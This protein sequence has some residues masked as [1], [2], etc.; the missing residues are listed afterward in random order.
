MLSLWLSVGSPCSGAY[1]MPKILKCLRCGTEFQPRTSGGEPQ[2][3][4]S[5]RCR[6]NVLAAAQMRRKRQDP[7]FAAKDRVRVHAWKKEHPETRRMYKRARRQKLSLQKGNFTTADWHRLLD[8]FGHKCAYCDSPEPLERD[9]IVPV[10]AGGKH[11]V[12]NV[13]PV[14]RKCNPSKGSKDLRT[15]LADEDRYQFVCD[16]IVLGAMP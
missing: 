2:V 10:T 11:D 7:A 16:T 6:R 5:G 13:A 9:H 8:I 15:W 3:Y 12:G 4:C 1:D 14:C